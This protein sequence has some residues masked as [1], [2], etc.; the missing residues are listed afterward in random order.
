MEKVAV[1]AAL[2]DIGIWTA[3][4]FDYLEPSVRVADAYLAR[5]GRARWAA[6]VDEMIREHHKLLPYRAHDDWLVEAFRRADLVDVSR[7]FTFGLPR[8]FLRAVFSTWPSLGFH[9]F[10]VKL[11]LRRWRGHPLSPLPM[12]RL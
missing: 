2:H 11:T 10:L 3:G 5:T 7:I 1:A 8:T 12:V 6:E 4:T 9:R